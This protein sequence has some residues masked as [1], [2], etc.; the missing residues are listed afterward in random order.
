MVRGKYMKNR[1]IRSLKRYGIGYSAFT[2][3]NYIILMLVALIMLIPYLHVMAK[4]FNE[5]SDTM[6]GG[7]LCWPRKFTLSN[8]LIIFEDTSIYSSVIVSLLR[9]VIGLVLGILIQFMVAYGLSRPN[10]PFK[11]A[12]TLYFI[13]PMYIGGGLIPTYILY[14]KMNLLNNFWVY[15]LPSL[16]VMYHVILIRSY[17]YSG[18]PNS[19]IESAFIDGASEMTCFMKIAL[20]LCKPILATVSLWIVVNHWNDWTSTLY[21]IRSSKLHTLMYKL[22]QLLKE[23]E[24][25]EQML[26]EAAKSGAVADAMKNSAPTQD[27]VVSAQVV[28]TTL[29]I[30]M[31]YP[32]LQ[33]YFINGVTIGAVKE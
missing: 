17:I 8:F 22:M 32:F 5:S 24:R 2:V 28:I 23:S 26:R 12:I 15:I 10:L 31:V 3:V 21:F 20:P 9:I 33:K 19:V 25:L 11:K 30:I 14:S 7:I 6:M 13:I 18:V 1:M 29:P 27:S 16:F 4:A